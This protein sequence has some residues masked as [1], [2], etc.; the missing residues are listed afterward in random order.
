MFDGLFII[1]VEPNF[2]MTHQPCTEELILLFPVRKCRCL[3]IDAAPECCLDVVVNGCIPDD[4]SF[5][6][7]VEATSGKPQI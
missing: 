1:F 7:G 4:A 3:I 6:S 2:R 5:V